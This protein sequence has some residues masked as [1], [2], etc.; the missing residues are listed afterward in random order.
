MEITSL[1][2]HRYELTPKVAPN[3]I[4][5]TKPRKGALLKVEFAGI[6]HA[7]HADLFPW[8][9]LGDETLEEQLMALRSGVP[10][11]LGAA[12]LSWAFYEAEAQ[13]KQRSLLQPMPLTMHATLAERTTPPQWCQLAKSKVSLSDVENWQSTEEFFLRSPAVKWRLDFNGLFVDIRTAQIFWRSVSPEFKQRIDF[14]EDPYCS[15]LM[16]DSKAMQVFRGT[17]IAV[18]RCVMPESLKWADVWVVKPVYFNPTYLAR[19]LASFDK[20]V[21]ITSNMDHPL[22]QIIALHMAQDTQRQFPALKLSCGLLTQELYGPHPQS[23]WLKE[24]AGQLVPTNSGVGWGLNEPLA[25]L[26]WE[27]IS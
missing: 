20:E 27:K 3:R 26:N 23:H 22:G 24:V 15:E 4:A 19:E 12:A 2:I 7:G 8:P 6:S 14:L 13:Q 5:S 11:R 1:V 16:A 18:D 21:V 9:E 25:E 17:R 10:F